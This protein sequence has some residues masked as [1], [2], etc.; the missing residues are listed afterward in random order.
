MGVKRAAGE[1]PV[2]GDRA[3]PDASRGAVP[4]IDRQHDIRA[5]AA[6]IVWLATALGCPAQ[7]EDD[8]ARALTGIVESAQNIMALAS[9]EFRPRAATAVSI[10]TMARAAAERARLEFPVT[11]TVDAAPALVVAPALD[12]VRVLDNLLAN[13]CRAAG[14]GG[15]VRVGVVERGDHVLIEIV[16][17]GPGIDDFAASRG[18][19]ISIVRRLVEQLGGRIALQRINDVGGT[20]A[21]VELPRARGAEALTA[22]PTKVNGRQTS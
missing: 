20:S 17:S 7:S 3:R 16:D 1:Q 10:D 2:I 11:V 9:D 19:G 15:I 14:V 18:L 8:G 6:T 4:S 13:A 22:L 5:A 12:I 21:R